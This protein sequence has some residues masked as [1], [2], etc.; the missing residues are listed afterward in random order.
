MKKGTQLL[1]IYALEIQMYT[2]QKNNKKLKVC[3]F[4]KLNLENV[5]IYVIIRCAVFLYVPEV[6]IYGFSDS[7]SCPPQI[8][9]LS[10]QKHGTE[11]MKD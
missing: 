11:G 2:S 6:H 1:E 10:V 7:L 9:V 8:L 4:V 3:R 5:L